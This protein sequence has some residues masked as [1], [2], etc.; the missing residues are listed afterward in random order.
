MMAASEGY[1]LC[2]LA[3]LDA[4][5][6]YNL[7]DYFQK[8]TALHMAAA[9]RHNIVVMALT[10]LPHIALEVKNELGH[11]SLHVAAGAGVVDSVR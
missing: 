1:T 5:A 2:V 7:R 6:E 11:T 9:G 4:G 8:S 3:L 10:H